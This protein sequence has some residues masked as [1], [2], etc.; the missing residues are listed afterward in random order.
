MERKIKVPNNLS[1]RCYRLFFFR[2]ANPLVTWPPVARRVV[3]EEGGEAD[4]GVWE[5]MKIA[6]CLYLYTMM[7]VV[8]L[9][10]RCTVVNLPLRNFS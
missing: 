7:I 4:V 2:F 3:K 9:G 5:K 8:I 10:A 6:S 1:S